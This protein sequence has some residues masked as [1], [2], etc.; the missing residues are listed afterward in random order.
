MKKLK[1]LGN[2]AYNVMFHT[3]TV[4]GIVISFGLFIIFYAGA[5]TLFFHELKQWENPDYRQP[6]VEDV[7][8]DMIV[9]QV[10]K[11]YKL[12]HTSRVNVYFPNVHEPIVKVFGQ[13]ATSDTTTEFVAIHYDTQEQKFY[14]SEEDKSTVGSTI[15]GLH[16]FRQIP[17][18]GLYIAGFV[19]LFFLFA[20]ITGILVHWR[21]LL[22]KFYSFIKEGKWKQ[23]WTN[24][25]TV[26]GVISFPFQVMYAVTGAF[27]GL[28]VLILIPV[29]FLQYDG[30]IN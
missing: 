16:Y 14:K 5:Y 1:G 25:H 24:A 15:Y 7:D 30:D 10:D 9:D 23:I 21:N 13:S 11:D 19:A 28:L 27:F 4:A 26:L 6:V 29:V 3:H 2:R 17:T 8:F 22:T 20:S 12:D 18:V